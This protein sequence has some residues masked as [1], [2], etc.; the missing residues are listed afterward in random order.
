MDRVVA[1]AD[2]MAGEAVEDDGEEDEVHLH[3]RRKTATYLRSGVRSPHCSV[4]EQHQCMPQILSNDTTIGI[5]V[6]RVDLMWKMDIHLQHAPGIGENLGTKKDAPDR[7]CSSTLRP[8][9]PHRSRDSIRISCL[10]VSD[11]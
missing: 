2:E 9:T 11:R 8:D 7:M 5:T 1:A 10:R 6:S 3:R 4:E